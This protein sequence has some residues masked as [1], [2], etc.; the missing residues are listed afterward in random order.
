MRST[1]LPFNLP[2]YGEDE[3]HEVLEALESGWLA[4]GP[5]TKQFEKGVCDYLEVPHAVG[6]NSGTAALHL[7]LAALGI[8]E[9]DEV[10]TTPFTFCST[11]NVILQLKAVPVLADISSDT[12]NIDPE[13]VSA[14][15]THKTRAIIPV[16]FGGHPC[17][18]DQLLD[19]SNEMG[20]SL[21][22]NATQALGAHY[23]GSAIG[24]ISDTTCFSLDNF[25]NLASGECGMIT[26]SRDDLEEKLRILAF[27]GITRNNITRFNS[28]SN[29]YYRVVAPGYEYALSEIQAAIGIHQLRKLESFITC[30]TEIAIKYRDAFKSVE[31][32][33]M[34]EVKSY[35][36]H[37]WRLFPILINTDMITID[38]AQ[39]IEE[40]HKRNIG[41]SVHFIP[42]HFHPF[43]KD[44]YGDQEGR[45]P[46]SEWIYYR[47]IS[48]PI[49][50][51]MT[52][53]DVNDVIE[54]VTDVI[55]EFRR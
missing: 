33:E 51:R 46:I 42:I 30:R 55:I 10:I 35:V 1:Y 21:I 49:Y 29:W 38:R 3:K 20:L 34:P 19:I 17:E 48:L 7:S 52:D 53:E 13:K 16:H 15:I 14:A 39:F 2:S 5:R 45:Y 47:E 50:P 4:S 54:A 23:K 9:G 24:K 31:A 41:T 28:E 11:V 27:H 12:W 37:A 44:I 40:L 6:V 36:R 43:Y 18:M 22:G 25:G 8:T 26:T 32:I